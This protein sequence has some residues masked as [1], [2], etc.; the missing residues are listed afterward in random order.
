MGAGEKGLEMKDDRMLNDLIDKLFP[1]LPNDRKPQIPSKFKSIDE[2]ALHYYTV[3]IQKK[4]PLSYWK[5]GLMYTSGK[6]GGRTNNSKAVSIWEEAVSEG[7]ADYHIC[8]A[9]QKAYRYV[10][11]I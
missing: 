7:L 11:S 1:R 4:S 10:P 6:V 5:K 9:L 8:Y 2:M 3:L